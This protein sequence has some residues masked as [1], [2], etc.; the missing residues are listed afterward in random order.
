MVELGLVEPLRA[1][2]PVWLIML[3]SLSGR[4]ALA[5]PPVDSAETD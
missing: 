5:D 3:G 2:N 4:V 1:I